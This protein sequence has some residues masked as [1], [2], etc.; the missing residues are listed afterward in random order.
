MSVTLPGPVAD[1]STRSSPIPWLVTSIDWLKRPERQDMLYAAIGGKE[2][3]EFPRPFDLLILDEAH[4]AAPAGAN[5]PV[6]SHRTRLIDWFGSY[7]EHRLFLTATPHNG[8]RQSF[9]ALLS[10]LDRVRFPSRELE[11][12]DADVERA[13]VRRL[14]DHVKEVDPSA[15][16]PKRE[17]HAAPVTPKK[18]EVDGYE[19]LGDVP[20]L[21]Q[22]TQSPRHCEGRGPIHGCHSSQAFPLLAGRV[23]K[24]D[25]RARSRRSTTRVANFPTSASQI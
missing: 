2:P 9:W 3:D 15:P 18:A 20:R 23:R 25:R 16:F 17:I 6:D 7:F 13:M 12:T 8:H 14:K 24:H 5:I 19:L 10:L 1:M 4:L 21:A 22:G 11:P